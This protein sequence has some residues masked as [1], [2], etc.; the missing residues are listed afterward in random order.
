MRTDDLPRLAIRR[1]RLRRAMAAVTILLPLG[2]MLAASTLAIL[3]LA[4]PSPMVMYLLTTLGVT[5]GFHRLVTHRSF[6][7]HPALLATA[8][9]LGSMSAQGSLMYWVGE[10]RRH[11]HHADCDGDPHTPYLNGKD[12]PA[13]L[14]GVLH[15]HIGW[16]TRLPETP[17]IP[18]VPDVLRN[19]RLAFV[20]RHYMSWVALGIL[21][22]GITSMALTGSWSECVM[23]VTWAGFARIG[24]VH[25]ATWSVN[26]ICHLS[27]SRRF[28]TPD[29]SRNNGLIAVVTLGEGWHNNHHA[30]P[31]AARH[32]LS[33]WELDATY[34]VI[35][36][37]AMFGL[38]RKIRL[39]AIYD[40]ARASSRPNG[41]DRPS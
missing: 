4:R 6:E 8:T 13:G 31:Y 37:M 19:R 3:G 20:E 18:L 17:W 5:M 1:M 41:E 29:A 33:R 39:P 36:L 14:R 15:A 11:H 32:G 23:A 2:I 21:L 9:I 38:A 22:P 16:M 27:G 28:S 26:S 25:Q 34:G 30:F 40:G 12:R 24:L 10:H 7:A 35:R